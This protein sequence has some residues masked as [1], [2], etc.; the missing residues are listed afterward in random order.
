MGIIDKYLP[1]LPKEVRDVIDQ[2]IANPDPPGTSVTA[3]SIETGGTPVAIVPAVPSAGQVLVASG[4][5]SAAWTTATAAAPLPE[6]WSQQNVAASQTDVAL[7]T[8][9]STSFATIKAIRAGSIT[10]LST[11]FSEAI[12][13]AT[14]NSC[15]VTVTVGGVAGTL[16]VSHAS[17]S[18][19]SGGEATQLDGIDTFVAGD[20]IG[21]QITTLASFLPIST[22]VEA[23][24]D[25]Q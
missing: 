24:L 3:D 6:K 10:G 19:A 18:N 4:P 20:L 23:W 22:D 7:G 5:A 1:N 25:V 15:V 2:E 17:G 9:I 14:A 16:S 11:R 12:T 8:L 13:D 21:V